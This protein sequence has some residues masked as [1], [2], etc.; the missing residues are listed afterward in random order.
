[1][2]KDIKH[3]IN[4]KSFFVYTA[5]AVL[6]C[7]FCSI[8]TAQAQERAT[9]LFTQ[10]EKLFNKK[11][12]YEA[13]QCYKKL[14]TSGKKITAMSQPFAVRKKATGKSG[15]D[16]RQEAIYHMAESYRRINDY[17]EAEKWYKEASSFSSKSYPETQYWYGISLRANGKY[18]EAAKAILAFQKSYTKMGDL[19]IGADKE[20]ENL[21]FIK[22]QELRLKDN[23]TI[24][25]QPPVAGGSAYALTVSQ[26]DSVVFTALK[27]DSNNT[28]E[29][30]QYYY[31]A[32]L[33]KSADGD[34]VSQ[35]ATMIPFPE[36]ADV[37]NGIATF[38]KKGNKMF[39]TR[40][41]KKNDNILSAIYS[42]D[43][44]DTGWT[45]PEKLGPPVNEEGSNSA[46]PSVTSDGKQLL[47]SSDRNGGFGK[48]DIWYA[49]L[50]TNAN[51]LKVHNMGEIINSP[52][53]EYSP[54]YHARSR[55]LMFSSNGRIG[56]GGFDI[57]AVKGDFQFL[58]WEQPVNPG[59][60]LNSSKDDLY[61]ISTDDEN[62]WNTGWLSSDRSTDCCLELFS[63]QQENAQYIT[64][65]VV[66][67][68]SN[69]PVSG[70]LLSIT[71]PRHG[72][73]VIRNEQTD[74]EGNYSFQMKNTSKFD[75][76]AEKQG[77]QPA[78]ESYTI[79]FETGK[80]SLHITDLC[81]SLIADSTGGLEDVLNSLS[82]SSTLAKFPYNKSRLDNA[83]LD[84]LDSIANLLNQFP[85]A[86]IEIGGYTDS[87]GSEAFNIKLAQKR[88]DEC[89]HYL[90]KKGI[91][92]DR[93]VGK[94]Y[95][96]CCPLEPEE[97]DGKDN[98]AAREKN[99]RVEYKLLKGEL[100]A[101]K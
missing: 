56:M 37:N 71:D 31:T 8:N 72:G 64:G 6:T 16:M 44:T 60:P 3:L 41:I 21:K 65:T 97:T 18:D 35:N 62:I 63:F 57:Y 67:C 30:K 91:S 58:R 59:T 23:F 12:Y 32:R 34:N 42:S 27:A 95:G 87:K 79:H 7:F 38:T 98:P 77:Y 99:R 11:S 73:K 26:N 69:T 50:D 29:G 88:V 78:N 66:D 24:T 80:D 25:K 36:A 101:D 39:F 93:L 61:F 94:A 100:G 10:G 15:L 28:K 92:A 75:I 68:K 83:Y 86:V 46:Q 85:S 55:N 84:K 48:Y 74:A 4:H 54:F 40:W 1:M 53:D 70:A 17:T 14:L 51:V 47:F 9:A 5:V 20:L 49:D 13:I 33:F 81:I 90:I 96:E 2:H 89:I 82:S 43:K 22:D 45:K 52:G 19:L 76:K